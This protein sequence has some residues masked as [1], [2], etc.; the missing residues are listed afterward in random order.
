VEHARSFD[1]PFPWRA[2]TAVLALLATAELIGLLALAG[3]RLVPS[4]HRAAAH[5]APATVARPSHG[6]AP[7][8]RRLAPVHPL[9]P[10]SRV[11][12]L[13]LNGNGVTGAA[14]AEAERLLARGYRH[15]LAADAPNHDYARS[16]V[17]F[18]PGWQREAQRLARETNIRVVGALDG[19]RTSQ[20]RGSQLVVILGDS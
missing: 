10:R 2:A 14:G 16:L 17:L 18:A 20:L 11:S 12:V 3:V 4:L 15:A 9:R 1:R 19:M 13:V 7:A 8:Q 6:H 5:A